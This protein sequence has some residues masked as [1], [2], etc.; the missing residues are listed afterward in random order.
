MAP[1][2]EVGTN[3]TASGAAPWITRSWRTEARP[4]TIAIPPRIHKTRDFR[5][6]AETRPVV[7]PMA[8]GRLEMKTATR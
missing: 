7:E 1:A 3:A 5:H 8:S 4:D 6:P 2:A